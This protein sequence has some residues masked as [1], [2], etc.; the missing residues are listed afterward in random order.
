MFNLD[1]RIFFLSYG[2][3]IL[4]ALT[5]TKFILMTPI[6]GYLE[7]VEL[8]NRE[9]KR[10]ITYFCIRKKNLKCMNVDKPYLQFFVKFLSSY[11][12]F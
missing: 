3:V 7:C 2:T 6:V 4:A 1:I 10:R 5:C 11:G 8:S 12:V 9:T